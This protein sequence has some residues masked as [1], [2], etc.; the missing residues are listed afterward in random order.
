[1]YMF[2]CSSQVF[3]CI[4][5]KFLP[6]TYTTFPL[7]ILEWRLL[8]LLF[9]NY[10]F[11][12]VSTL[13]HDFCPTILNLVSQS[14][15][16]SP[17]FYSTVFVATYVYHTLYISDLFP[18]FPLVLSFWMCQVRSDQFVLKCNAWSTET[19]GEIS[20]VSDSCTPTL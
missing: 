17:F 12:K 1:M 9:E 14:V 18:Y 2:D 4:E 16:M 10:F 8:T 19:G 3:R 7:N 5:E 15:S 11:K 6:L 20:V 13:L